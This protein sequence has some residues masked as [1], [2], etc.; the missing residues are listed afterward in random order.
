VIRALLTSLFI[1][2][3]ILNAIVEKG[4]VFT[5]EDYTHA[6]ELLHR[7]DPNSNSTIL[8]KHVEKLHS[9]LEV[10]GVTV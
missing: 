4:P 5:K 2:Q 10:A 9:I 7:S 6:L 3:D 8:N 1:F